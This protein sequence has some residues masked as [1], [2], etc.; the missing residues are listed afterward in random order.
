MKRRSGMGIG[1][2]AHL[3][4]V[5]EPAIE[6]LPL[7]ELD[8]LG[9]S[10]VDIVAKRQQARLVVIPAEVQLRRHSP[11]VEWE[12]YEV[13]AFRHQRQQETCSIVE[14]YTIFEP[15]LCAS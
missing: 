8:L 12:V 13:A 14:P 10:H 5:H 2:I 7:P 6:V 1:F 3:L 11:V 4:V 15:L 9:L